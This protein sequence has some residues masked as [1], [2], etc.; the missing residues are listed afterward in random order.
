MT[1]RAPAAAAVLGAVLDDILHELRRAK[2]RP[3]PHIHKGAVAPCHAAA[4]GF[5]WLAP[6]PNDPS[7]LGLTEAGDAALRGG[8]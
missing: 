7:W 4:I 1:P 5:G 3:I 8:A 6:R 2:R